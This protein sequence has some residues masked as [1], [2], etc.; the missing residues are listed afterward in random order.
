MSKLTSRKRRNA[1]AALLAG[2][3]TSSALVLPTVAG[4]DPQDDQFLA[5]VA[6]QGITADPE[7]LISAALNMCNVVGGMGA[8][9]PF[10]RLMASQSLSPVQASAVFTAGANAYC[11]D[12]ARFI[13]Q[14]PG[15]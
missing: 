1:A 14:P 7:Q 6:A 11:P 8:V 4:A 10:Y 15:M 9:G 2:C 3:L 5:A 13:A 12:K